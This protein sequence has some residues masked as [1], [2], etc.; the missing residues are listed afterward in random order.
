MRRGSFDFASL[1]I[2]MRP[3]PPRNTLNVGTESA[4]FVPYFYNYGVN[5]VILRNLKK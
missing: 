1:E 5:T 4:D 3:T 2:P